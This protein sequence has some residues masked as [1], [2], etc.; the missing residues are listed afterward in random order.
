M[1]VSRNSL[2]RGV[3]TSSWY[4]TPAAQRLAFRQTAKRRFLRPAFM[5]GVK[6]RAAYSK[7]G[8]ITD[9]KNV[10]LAWGGGGGGFNIR[11]LIGSSFV[12]NRACAMRTLRNKMATTVTRPCKNT[13]SR[14]FSSHR[15]RA[16]RPRSPPAYLRG[17]MCDRHRD[18]YRAHDPFAIYPRW[19]ESGKEEIDKPGVFEHSTRSRSTLTSTFSSY[20]SVG[21]WFPCP[22]IFLSFLYCC[23]ALLFARKLFPAHAPG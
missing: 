12:W 9:V 8:W 23:W 1:L 19:R 2:R 5:L 20:S 13:R 3:V 22:V 18:R 17:R 16:E 10:L 4:P 6:V 15:D 21:Y 11:T 7:S 14:I